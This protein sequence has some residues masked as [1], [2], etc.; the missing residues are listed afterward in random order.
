MG[1]MRKYE[2]VPGFFAQDNDPGVV[3]ELQLPHYG[4]STE[5][6]LPRFGLIDES[7]DRWTQFA[8]KIEQ[9]N[10]TAAPGVHYKVFFLGRHGQGVHNVAEAKYGT[11]VGHRLGGFDLGYFCFDLFSM[12]LTGMGK[13]GFRF[14][15]GLIASFDD[16]I[17][18][19]AKLNGD[20]DLVWGPDAQLTQLG[21]QQAKDARL[22]WEKE[23]QF[24]IPLP[25]FLYT[26]PLTRAIQTNQITFGDTLGLRPTVVEN[27]REHNGVHTCDKRR[28]R[29]EIQKDF[30]EIHFEQGFTE[31]DL[32]WAPDYRET[33]AN[34]DLR[35][36]DVLDMIFDNDSE[37]ED[38]LKFISITTHGGFIG[39]F[40]RVCNHRPWILPTGG[41]IPI[42]VKGYG[43]M[44]N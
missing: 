5:K 30:P 36:R 43:E 26:S 34:I 20:G 15:G 25:E 38:K 3:N 17:R 13:V 28:T 22:E 6:T 11:K 19:W 39:G 33:Y 29:S 18:Y 7:L 21:V 4:S 42:V 41:V 8:A 35:V 2:T 32:L 16:R 31:E 14:V 24:H 37:A 44:R 27:I 9:L 10:K 12:R 23:R 40:L 1:S